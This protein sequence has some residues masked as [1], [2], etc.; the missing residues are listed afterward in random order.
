VS[1][2]RLQSANNVVVAAVQP[3]YLPWKG[4]F[5]LLGLADIF[6]VLDD[7]QYTRRDW[8]NRNRIKTAG[9]VNWI[10]VPVSHRHNTLIR[11]VSIADNSF[12]RRHFATIRQ[13]YASAT[14]IDDLAPF[15]QDLYAAKRWKWLM[16]LNLLAIDAIARRFLAIDTQILRAS[17]IPTAGD[18]SQR[19][20]QLV[21]AVGGTHYLSGPAAKSYLDV[22]TFE[23]AGIGVRWMDY[24]G[25]PAYPQL[26]GLFR[27]DVTVLDL[28]AHTGPAAR[29]Y[30]KIGAAPS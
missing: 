9:G 2:P 23:S 6:V 15:L 11:D 22:S 17:D 4:Y 7:V 28:L 30:M 3:N 16:D 27:H 1:V 21:R 14:F 18:A 20:C 10:T 29:R 19:L 12:Q 13:A 26:H 24:S 5:D 8:R 25:Y